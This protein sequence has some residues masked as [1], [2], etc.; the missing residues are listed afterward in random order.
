M[1]PLPGLKSA[2]TSYLK[3]TLAYLNLAG[4]I[5][6]SIESNNFARLDRFA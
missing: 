5:V 4:E 3:L 2:R 6:E 1:P